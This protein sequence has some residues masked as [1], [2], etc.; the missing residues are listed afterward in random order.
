VFAIGPGLGYGRRTVQDGDNVRVAEDFY[1]RFQQGDMT[2]FDLVDPEI[3]FQTFFGDVRGIDDLVS[4]LEGVNEVFD[5]PGPDAEEFIAFQDGVVVVG[6]WRGRVKA[7][8]EQ[9]EARFA[10]IWGCRDGRLSVCRNFVD[11]AKVI[12]ALEGRGA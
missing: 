10:H 8:G 5:E 3:D 9:V 2:C 12:R 7:T 6:I 4:Y 1:R 11:S